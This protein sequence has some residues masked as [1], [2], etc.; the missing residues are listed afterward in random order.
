MKLTRKQKIALEFLAEV[1]PATSYVIGSLRVLYALE[2]KGLATFYAQG[3]HIT[4][5]GREALEET[6][7]N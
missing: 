5:K 6:H 2:N 7:G 4:R 1:G 3:F